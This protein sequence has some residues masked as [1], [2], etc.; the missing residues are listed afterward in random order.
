MNPTSPQGVGGLGRLLFQHP[1]FP[2]VRGLPFPPTPS[3]WTWTGVVAVSWSVQERLGEP[4]TTSKMAQDSLRC[5]KMTP[6]I[7]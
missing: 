7:L 3:P 5:L 1:S 4:K 6:K 2:S